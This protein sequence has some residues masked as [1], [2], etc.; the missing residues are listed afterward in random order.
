MAVRLEIIEQKV[1]D[2]KTNMLSWFP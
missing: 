2:I 1:I